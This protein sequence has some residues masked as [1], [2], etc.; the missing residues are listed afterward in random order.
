[1]MHCPKRRDIPPDVS[2][3]RSLVQ[4]VPRDGGWRLFDLIHV[5]FQRSSLEPTLTYFR[6]KHKSRLRLRHIYIL[7]MLIWYLFD[8]WLS[9]SLCCNIK[10]MI[11]WSKKNLWNR[12]SI[13]LTSTYFRDCWTWAKNSLATHWYECISLEKRNISF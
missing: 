1:M 9:L 10:L 4:E 6:L 2:R 13:S 7:F 3:P 8:H 5:W 12:T 11:L